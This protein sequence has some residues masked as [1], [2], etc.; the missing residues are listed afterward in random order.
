MGW[1]NRT[2]KQICPDRDVLYSGDAKGTVKI[3]DLTAASEMASFKTKEGIRS[4]HPVNERELVTLVR[5]IFSPLSST[6]IVA[7]SV[8][9]ASEQ[10]RAHRALGY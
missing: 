2:L 6:R 8:D 9:F 5:R 7:E 1:V 10:G 4:L 3:W